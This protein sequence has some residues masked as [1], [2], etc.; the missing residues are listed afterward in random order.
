MQSCPKCRGCSIG[1]V[2]QGRRC[3]R[4]GDTRHNLHTVKQETVILPDMLAPSC[5]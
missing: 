2:Q 1:D 5:D 4:L 3:R